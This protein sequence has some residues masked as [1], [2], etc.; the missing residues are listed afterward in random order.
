MQ[1]Q[2]IDARLVVRWFGGRFVP[3][4]AGG[5][6]F[7]INGNEGYFIRNFGSAGTFV[8]AGPMGVAK[9]RNAP[10]KAEPQATVPD[11]RVSNVTD[12][13]FTI[14]WLSTIAETGRVEWGT[15]DGVYPNTANDA[16]GA[17]TSSKI[18]YVNVVDPAQIFPENTYFYRI[19]SGASEVARGEV[20][21]GASASPPAPDTI[22]GQVRNSAGA[23]IEAIVYYQLRD[24]NGAGTLGTSA[25]FSALAAS[26][27]NYN[28]DLSSVRTADNSVLFVYSSTDDVVLRAE[29]G[30][31]DVTFTEQT[32]SLTIKVF[33]KTGN[34][35]TLS[36]PTPTPTP[37]ITNTPTITLTP[38]QTPTPTITLTP[39]GPPTDTPTITNTPTA[40]ATATVTVTPT[41]TLTPCVDAY[42]PDNT[43][44]TAKPIAGG[45]TQS[46]N[47]NTAGDV[48]WVNLHVTPYYSYTIEAFGPN[49]DLELY[50]TNSSDTF[51]ITRD[52]GGPGSAETF[53]YQSSVSDTLSI[54]VREPSGLAGGCTTDYNYQLRV[55]INSTPTVTATPSATLTPVPTATPHK[56]YISVLYKNVT[57]VS[58]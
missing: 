12:Q 27:G 8:P 6:T 57:N 44:G 4:Q 1:G 23:G 49:L 39:G 46:H 26:N 34:N 18:H 24:F 54:R 58:W 15:T 14:S 36:G 37:T 35:I 32:G 53:S 31:R 55:V 50:A 52:A 30:P 3:Y 51:T 16:R 28:A 29:A 56:V 7:P 9:T 13:G 40:T 41:A 48:D 2:G 5:V 10:P 11:V 22:G 45:E 25:L 47:I 21:T 17:S 33:S 42:E 19:V 38:T 20:T 43:R